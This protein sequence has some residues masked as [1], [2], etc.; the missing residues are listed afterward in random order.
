[1]IVIVI[2][3]LVICYL[4]YNFFPSCN[5]LSQKECSDQKTYLAKIDR[6]IQKPQP[7]SCHFVFCRWYDVAGVERV[8]PAPLGWYY[9]I[10]NACK[11]GQHNYYYQR[12]LIEQNNYG[13]IRQG[14]TMLGVS[15]QSV[16]KRFTHIRQKEDTQKSDLQSKIA[17]VKTFLLP[18]Q[19][20]APYTPNIEHH[21]LT[22]YWIGACLGVATFVQGTVVQDDFC[23]RRH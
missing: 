8:P 17:I 11:I 6:S 4:L 21:T 16:L 19:I 23:P 10:S 7:L 9:S 18:V 2:L 13:R 20:V 3:L 15:I 14:C 12:V 1:M 22:G 5:L